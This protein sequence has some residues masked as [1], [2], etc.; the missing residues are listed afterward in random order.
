MVETLQSQL[1]FVRDVQSVDTSGVEPLRSVRDETED[2]INEQ[3][4]GLAEL[5]T[6]LLKEKVIGHTRRPRRAEQMATTPDVGFW[7]PLT[8]A[9]RRAGSFFVVHSRR[10]V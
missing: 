9:S 3:K 8:S 2:G 5:Q 6:S 7:E 1:Q 10:N 4:V